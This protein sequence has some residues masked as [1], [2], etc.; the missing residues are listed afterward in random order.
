MIDNKR[1]QYLH[2]LIPS[3][4]RTITSYEITKPRWVHLFYADNSIFRDIYR[5]IRWLLIPRL[6]VSLGHQQPFYWL[7]MTNL[8]LV[9]LKE[10][11]QLPFPSQCRRFEYLCFLKKYWTHNG[12]N[13][14]MQ[15]PRYLGLMRSISW[16][17]MPWLLALSGHQQPWY[18]LCEISKS[19]SYMRKDSN[20][21]CYV[22]AEEW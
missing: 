16:L 11:Y 3:W 6:L 1:I 17:L 7:C 21:L 19:L 8:G 15:G 20:Y 10:G 2:Y 18:W 9:F 22:S 14:S 12:L 4:P 5:S 13:L